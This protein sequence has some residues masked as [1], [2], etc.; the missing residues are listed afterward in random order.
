MIRR[1]MVLDT[2]VRTVRCGVPRVRFGK[3]GCWT[4]ETAPTG[5][6]GSGCLG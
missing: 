1:L 4:A 2:L 5:S 3:L 6:F